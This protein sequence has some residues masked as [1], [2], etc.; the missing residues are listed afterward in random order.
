MHTAID[1]NYRDASNY[2]ASGTIYLDGPLSVDDIAF[3]KSKLN[4]SSYFIP[5]DLT[6]IEVAE[7]QSTLPSFPSEDDHVWHE[8]ELSG[9]REEP[10]ILEGST[11]T[12]RA[13]F[14]AAFRRIEGPNGWDVEGAVLRLDV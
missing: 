11:V 12:A 13:A 2:K 14:V 6:G 1:Y 8:L 10:S 7:L 9:I 4:E 3:I 5:G